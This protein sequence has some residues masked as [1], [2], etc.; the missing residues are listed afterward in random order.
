L[1]A[2]SAEFLQKPAGADFWKWIK[3][4]RMAVEL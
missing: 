3:T 1:D 4:A 2:I